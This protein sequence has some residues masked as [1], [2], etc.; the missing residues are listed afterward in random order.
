MQGWFN[1]GKFIKVTH[2]INKFKEKNH[3]IISVDADKVLYY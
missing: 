1:R 3:M 2:Y